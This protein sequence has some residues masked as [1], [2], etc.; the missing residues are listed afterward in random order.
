MASTNCLIL[1]LT[2][3]CGFKNSG[4]MTTTMSG[5]ILTTMTM[6]HWSGWNLGF[7]CRKRR[8]GGSNSSTSWSNWF[9]SGTLFGIAC[10]A[11]L[12]R[13]GS[14]LQYHPVYLIVKQALLISAFLVCSRVGSMNFWPNIRKIRSFPNC[15]HG[16]FGPETF[17]EKGKPFA[18]P[19]CILPSLDHS[20]LALELPDFRYPQYPTTWNMCVTSI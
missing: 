18:S 12:W 14:K 3:R 1:K 4:K 11:P 17:K 7:K 8:S 15:K 10:S 16:K 20:G 2:P 9:R 19:R 13:H 6:P 5:Q